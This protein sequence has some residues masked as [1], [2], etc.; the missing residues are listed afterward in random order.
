MKIGKIKLDAISGYER[1]GKKRME[2]IVGGYDY[3]TNSSCFFNCLEYVGKEFYNSDLTCDNYGNAYAQGHGDYKGTGNHGDYLYGPKFLNTDNSI[4]TETL[5]NLAG[6]TTS[7]FDTAASRFTMG[8]DVASLFQNGNND[9]V[10]GLINNNGQPHAVIITGYDAQSGKYS[11]YDP[12]LSEQ[13]ENQ[14]FDSDSLY[15]AIDC[16]Q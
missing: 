11:Y 10:I 7:Y 4:N 16:K 15:G 5:N 3:N 1:L 12:S 9:G 2:R 8:E 13:K 14:T 6:L